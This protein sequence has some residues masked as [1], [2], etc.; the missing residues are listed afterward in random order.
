M[1]LVTDYL[2]Y[3]NDNGACIGGVQP[4]N[5]Q[6]SI[7]GDIFMK[8]YF[9]LFDKTQSSPQTPD[10]SSPEREAK[11]VQPVG[12]KDVLSVIGADGKVDWRSVDGY[13]HLPGQIN[14]L[15][16]LSK[17]HQYLVHHFLTGVTQCISLHPSIHAEYCSALAPLALN[18]EHG[19]HL[20]SACLV[21]AARHRQSLGHKYNDSYIDKLATL[22]IGHLARQP[23]GKNNK[24]NQAAAATALVLCIAEIQAG[25]E[26]PDT[27]KIHLKG[28]KAILATQE[29]DQPDSPTLRLLR[30]WCQSLDILS[31]SAG[32]P[33]AVP[34][35]LNKVD[36]GYIDMFE[37]FSTSLV[38]IF[39]E[40][41]EVGRD[42]VAIQ[43]L[44]AASAPGSAI[45]TLAQTLRHRCIR[46]DQQIGMQAYIPCR[47]RDLSL[48]VVDGTF[49]DYQALNEIY[50]HAARLE[51]RIN[52]LLK[53]LDDPETM[54]IVKAGVACLKRMELKW[55]RPACKT[56]HSAFSI[57]SAAHDK[58]DRAFIID[59][60]D[61]LNQLFAMG[62]VLHARTI[63][64]EHWE[65]LDA[66]LPFMRPRALAGKKGWDLIF[67]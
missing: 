57:G 14:W 46:L 42:A 38:P 15:S 41:A 49:H 20:L 64:L 23:I 9:V 22:S 48:T 30:R 32:K 50:H 8:H 33:S 34:N 25:G 18:K 53:P 39:Q 1:S 11:A 3:A 35:L 4:L 45:H 54:D 27:W 40:M 31:M 65:R 16:W 67:Y 59:W 55:S 29:N 6:L 26:K 62:N 43:T 21:A 61:R 7:F 12:V 36:P 37:G 44:Q 2:Q 13:L 24:I 5:G 56:L 10:S 17:P 51:I 19:V 63:L 28:A 52:L 66:G 47:V 60:L 58:D